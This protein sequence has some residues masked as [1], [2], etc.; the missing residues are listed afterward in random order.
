MGTRSLIAIWLDNTFKLAQF[1]QFDGYPEGIGLECLTFLRRKM[2]IE[3]F[4]QALRN[5][6][7]A[8]KDYIHQAWLE[9][10]A[11]EEGCLDWNGSVLMAKKYPQF[12]RYTGAKILSFVQR[13]PE[14]IMAEN[15]ITFAADG[16]LCNWAWVIDFDQMA[17]EAYKGGSKVPLS[18]DERFS[19][20]RDFETDGYSAVKLVASFSLLQLPSKEAFLAAF[21][22]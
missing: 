6:R 5:T 3:Q 11:D 9:C 1:C 13:H 8:S 22:K 14:G 12:S 4:K 2:E 7:F 10:G 17:F 16:L 20:L 18:D 21:D 19:F 15:S